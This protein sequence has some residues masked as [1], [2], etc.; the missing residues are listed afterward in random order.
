MKTKFI[1]GSLVL[2]VMGCTNTANMPTHRWASTEDADRAK[3]QQDH[4]MCQSQS[5]LSTG[6]SELDT[7]SSAFRLYKQCMNNSGYV[8]TAYNDR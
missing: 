7:D 3:Y 4:A 5:G 2:L 1:L 6:R 8:L